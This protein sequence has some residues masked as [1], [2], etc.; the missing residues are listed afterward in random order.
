MA[1]GLDSVITAHILGLIGMLKGTESI[2]LNPAPTI[3]LGT[4]LTFD[5]VTKLNCC[6]SS[7]SLSVYAPVCHT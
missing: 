7:P 3:H 4:S 5:T 1:K 6:S 2:Y